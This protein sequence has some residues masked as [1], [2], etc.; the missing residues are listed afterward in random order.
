[1][2]RSLRFKW[3]PLLL[4]AGFAVLLGGLYLWWRPGTEEEP[5]VQ[6]VGLERRTA[7]P[8]TAPMN[9]QASQVPEQ[10]TSATFAGEASDGHFYTQQQLTTGRPAVL[11]FIKDDCPCSEIAQPLFNRLFVAYGARVNFLGVIDAE[12]EVAR[13]WADRFDCPY[14]ILAD[15]AQKVIQTYRAENSAYVALLAPGGQLKHLWPGFSRSMLEELGELL[16]A[17]SQQP[18]QTLELFDAPTRM[19]SGCPFMA[20]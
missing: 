3:D 19:Y 8:V 7:H 5:P 6:V 16:A 14:P 4:L 10:L 11:V 17:L 2:L 9:E 1:M 20:D 12:V 15:P 13:D 18:P